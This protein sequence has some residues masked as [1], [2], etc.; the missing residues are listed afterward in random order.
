[1]TI[2]KSAAAV[3]MSTALIA[4]G[5]Y[6]DGLGT[7]VGAAPPV[8]AQGASPVPALAFPGI[9]GSASA[10]PSPGG[11]AFVGVTYVNPRDGISGRGG[12]GDLSFGYTFG[13]PVR[14]VSV[15]LAANILGLD[16]FGESGEFYIGLSRMLQASGNSATFIGASSNGW[17]AWGDA[18]GK[19]VSNAIYVSHLAAFP[20]ANGTELP[21]QFT[22]GY[23]NNTTLSDTG[24]GVVEAGVFYGVGVGVT[25]NLSLSLSGT[26]TQVNMGLGLSVPTVPGLGIT[27]GVLDVTDNTNRQQFSLT[28]AF[29]F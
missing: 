9:Y 19:D 4:T 22:L 29:A 5:A 26:E 3:A 17:G 24:N 20:L 11:T 14:N 8:I 18:E 6:A 21:V 27:A 1:M 23:G 13:S 25:Q 10:I 28:A 15:T 2:K 12:D 16:P 7:S